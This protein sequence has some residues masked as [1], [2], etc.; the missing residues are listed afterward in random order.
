MSG[1]LKPTSGV[2][3]I[4]GFSVEDNIER[5]RKYIGYCP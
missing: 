1:E 4:E 3:L 2:G 5:A